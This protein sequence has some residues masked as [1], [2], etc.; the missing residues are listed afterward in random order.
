MDPAFASVFPPLRLQLVSSGWEKCACGYYKQLAFREMDG[1]GMGGVVRLWG[2]TLL[3][4]H[5]EGSKFNFVRFTTF[6]FMI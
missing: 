4:A 5:A 6:K 2:T 1:E 3:S